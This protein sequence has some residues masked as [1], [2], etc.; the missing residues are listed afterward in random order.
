MLPNEEENDG[1]EQEQLSP[2]DLKEIVGG[3]KTGFSKLIDA[4]VKNGDMVTV[5]TLLVS[6]VRDPV[7]FAVLMKCIAS[8]LRDSINN[9][10]T[11]AITTTEKGNMGSENTVFTLI[12]RDLDDPFPKKAFELIESSFGK[13]LK[14][15]EASDPEL[16]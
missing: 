7:H 14:E 3:L 1:G 9:D 12:V 5:Q 8:V 6:M 10:A 11:I 4:Y 16:N 15:Y 13:A 2:D